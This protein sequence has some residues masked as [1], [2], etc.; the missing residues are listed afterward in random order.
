[1]EAQGEARGQ[2]LKVHQCFEVSGGMGA[3]GRATI[4]SA[5]R[6]TEA[7]H[8]RSLRG[9]TEMKEHC[10]NQPGQLNQQIEI[11]WNHFEEGP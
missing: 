11:S 7:V 10:W 5:M 3:E 1:L 8:S 9:P 6:H 4:D 2:W